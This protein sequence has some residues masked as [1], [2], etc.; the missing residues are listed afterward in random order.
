MRRNPLYVFQDNFA[1]GIFEVP[2]KSM[3]QVID[4]DGQGTP[5]IVQIIS[6]TGLNANS[7]IAD[8]L[9]DSSLYKDNKPNS[10]NLDDLKDA[11]VPTPQ[12][13]EVLTYDENLGQ[14]VNSN[15]ISGGTF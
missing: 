5:E 7:T 9:A 13:G 4:S 10:F 1:L 12:S 14:W 8:F 15:N 6:K 3:I 2:L 11:D